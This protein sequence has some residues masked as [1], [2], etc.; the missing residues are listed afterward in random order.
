MT[1]EVHIVDRLNA[2]APKEA[3]VYWTGFL[4]H[5]RKKHHRA[6]EI[7]DIAYGHY[8]AGRVDL[9]QRKL[10]QDV[11][12]Y[13]AVGLTPPYKPPLNKWGVPLA[14]ALKDQPSPAKAG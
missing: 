12:D 7:A 6:N 3:V 2:L 1:D 14:H 5:D 9:V 10:G 4:A 13:I 8:L 11:Y